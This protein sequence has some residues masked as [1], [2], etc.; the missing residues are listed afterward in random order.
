M[1]MLKNSLLTDEGFLNPAC[2]NELEAVIRRI[3]PDYERLSNDPE[4]TIGK[5]HSQRHEEGV[6]VQLRTPS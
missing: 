2:M 6:G 4:W 3:P 1:E 5:H